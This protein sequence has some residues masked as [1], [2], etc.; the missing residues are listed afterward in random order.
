MEI[1]FPCSFARNFHLLQICHDDNAVELNIY[2]RL[3]GNV[4]IRIPVPSTGA[5][6]IPP[7][8]TRDQRH[9]GAV[10]RV[11]VGKLELAFAEIT[12][13]QF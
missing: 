6:F 1:S 4:L 9:H 10:L 3:P 5:Y 8:A 11:L 12:S 13:S 2:L 7:H